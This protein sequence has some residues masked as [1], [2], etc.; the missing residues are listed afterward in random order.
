MFSQPGEPINM[1]LL[2]CTGPN[3]PNPFFDYI[4]MIS[5]ISSYANCTTVCVLLLAIRR[6]VIFQRQ[7][8]AIHRQIALR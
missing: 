2:K 5:H 3:S 7:V 6:V 4:C 8:S 1:L